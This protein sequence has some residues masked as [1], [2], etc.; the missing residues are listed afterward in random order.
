M[1]PKSEQ[2]IHLCFVYFVC[3][4]VYTHTRACIH[5]GVKCVCVCMYTTYMLGASEIR[6]GYWILWT[7]VTDSC[8]ELYG[9]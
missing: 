9:F 6:K 7:R 1:G 8:E 4:C 2:K 3:V 5:A